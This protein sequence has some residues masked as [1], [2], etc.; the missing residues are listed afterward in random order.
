M[1]K[2]LFISIIFLL[3]L[4]IV[5]GQ[6]SITKLEL[7]KKKVLFESTLKDAIFIV[8]NEPN[9]IFQG[10]WTLKF[11][12]GAVLRVHHV[13]LGKNPINDIWWVGKKYAAIK[14]GK[15]IDVRLIEEE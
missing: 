5:S 10:C 14:K 8:D 3:I 2:A 6:K 13:G 1:R 12:N 11:D 7:Q 15:I 4:S 9:T